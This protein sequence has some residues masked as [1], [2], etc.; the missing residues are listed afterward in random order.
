MVTRIVVVALLLST[1]A[2]CVSGETCGLGRCQGNSTCTTLFSGS[3]TSKAAGPGTDID[4]N[5]WCVGPCTGGKACSGGASDAGSDLCLEDPTD[6]SVVVCAGTTV[7]MTL[8]CP[9]TL[10]AT[11]NGSCQSFTVST[12]EVGGSTPCAAGK[13]C[14][15]GPFHS[16]QVI[17]PIVMQVGNGPLSIDTSSLAHT[18][19]ANPPLSQT[20]PVSIVPQINVPSTCSN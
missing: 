9:N 10:G 12:C 6:D 16:G 13:T 5:Y 4:H 1:A 7:S 11:I 20:L 8:S 18:T 17:G 3:F 15:V 14:S 19:D 2:G